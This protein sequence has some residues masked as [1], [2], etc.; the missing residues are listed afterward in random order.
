[1]LRFLIGVCLISA[2]SLC[3]NARAQSQAAILNVSGTLTLGTKEQP[4]TATIWRGKEAS[5]QRFDRDTGEGERLVLTVVS[6]AQEG[7]DFI[8]YF[9]VY[10]Y[11]D[12]AWIL[13][14]EPV[15]FM[16]E[17][18]K[19]SVAVDAPE[20]PLSNYFKLEVLLEQEPLGT[21][22]IPPTDG[23]ACFSDQ[24]TYQSAF[25]GGCCSSSCTVDPGTQTC[26]GTIV[27]CICGGCCQTP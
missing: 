11:R 20:N 24:P 26:C 2:F 16:R 23:M 3:V 27:C 7:A 21:D 18:Q 25:M 8:A 9:R 6:G 10:Q 12:G 4:F 5:I 15:L 22:L 13:R 1:M 17:G 14:H 19:G